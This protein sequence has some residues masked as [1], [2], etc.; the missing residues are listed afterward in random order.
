M[1]DNTS[2]RLKYTN[3]ETGNQ[4][5]LFQDTLVPLCRRLR[6][7]VFRQWGLLRPASALA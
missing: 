2:A 3:W 1:S 6:N 7:T 5:T 4:L